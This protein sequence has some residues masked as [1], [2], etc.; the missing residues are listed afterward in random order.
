MCIRDSL[1]GVLGRVGAAVKVRGMFLHPRQAAAVL[2]GI[3]D[4]Q[5]WRFLID[6]VDHKDELS[7]EVVVREGASATAVVAQV[8]DRVRAG[9]RFA[10]AVA[11]VPA[12]PGDATPI[13]DR[14]DWS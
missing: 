8:A 9:L 5:A 3:A 14:R 4:V 2:D 6:R 11:A 12:L 1:A 10:C 13:V 7:C